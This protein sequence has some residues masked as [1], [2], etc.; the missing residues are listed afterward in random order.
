MKSPEIQ[1]KLHEAG[2]AVAAAAG[3]DYDSS[4]HLASFVAIENVYPITQKAYYRELNSNRLLKAV[5]QVG[6]PT[7]KPRI[8]VSG[9]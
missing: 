1:E 7:A 3:E 4:T 6:L 5:G 2:Q 9:W 8:D